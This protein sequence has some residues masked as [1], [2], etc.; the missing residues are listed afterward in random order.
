M[1]YMCATS[2]GCS[3]CIFRVYMLLIIASG[4]LYD[5]LTAWFFLFSPFVHICN[6]WGLP[7]RDEVALR[8]MTDSTKMWS[9]L[10]KIAEAELAD[11]NNQAADSVTLRF[12]SLA[13]RVA[14]LNHAVQVGLG[15]GSSAEAAL[16]GDRAPEAEAAETGGEPGSNV[17]ASE[18]PPFSRC[19]YSRCETQHR[20]H[21]H[22]LWLCTTRLN[23][24]IQM[25]QAS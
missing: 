7:Y 2:V 6:K 17:P 11:S 14:R 3:D 21:Y 4:S 25:L 9:T 1:V 23:Q 16:E 8:R 5:C 24:M 15:G 18:D 19:G 20:H 12:L 10:K 22:A 13:P